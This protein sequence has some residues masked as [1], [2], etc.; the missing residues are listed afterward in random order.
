MKR[1]L[2]LSLICV[3]GF[4]FAGMSASL[5]G[6]WDTDVT[7][8]VTQSDFSA[9]LG[10]TSKLTVNYIIGDWTFTSITALTD[11]GW[12]DQDFNATGILGAFNITTALDLNPDATFG[13]LDV[14][15]G[16]T[17]SGVI[18]GVDIDLIGDDLFMDLTGSGVAG[19]G[20][21]VDVTVSFGDDDGECDL[22]W[23][24]FDIVIGFSFCCVELEAEI[25]F[26]CDGLDAIVFSFGGLAVPNLPWLT[27]D[28]SITFDLVD[29]KT[30]VLEPSLDFGVDVC[31]NLY[32]DLG[33]WTAAGNGF[34]IT[35]ITLDGISLSCY[36]GGVL[37]E[38]IT[39]W[40]EPV[41]GAKKNDF[42]GLLA[43]FGQQ[44]F[45]A[46]RIS[47][48]DDAC[49]GPFGFSLAVYF[50]EDLTDQLFDI[51]LFV[52]S[53]SLE[54]ATQFTFDMG[55]SVD[56]TGGFTEWTVGFLVTW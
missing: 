31:F 54:V 23:A 24:G 14:T 20:V 17:F 52:A 12:S 36:V 45:E 5:T 38:G 37:F 26:D 33:G 21:T 46:Y 22:D 6:S 8:D 3:L 35:D 28:G 56:A 34:S 9:A 16:L 13:D 42:P 44:Y 18:L 43:G 30:V 10:L 48:D 53:V 47:T 29:G 2:V 7:I 11:A 55:L 27:I 32:W 25:T 39:Y 51:D 40:G 1:A 15:V 4:A 19:E 49:C 41:Y 50:E